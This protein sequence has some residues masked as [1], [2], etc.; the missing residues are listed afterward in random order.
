MVRKVLLWSVAALALLLVAVVLI[1]RYEPPLDPQARAVLE[2]AHEALPPEQNLLYALLGFDLKAEDFARAGQQRAQDLRALAARGLSDEEFSQQSELPPRDQIVIADRDRLGAD[3]DRLHLFQEAMAGVTNPAE[4]LA[5]NAIHL[6]RYEA[7]RH[8]P[9]FVDLPA[10]WQA[11]FVIRWSPMVQAGQLW[12]IWLADEI[13]KGRTDAALADLRDDADFWRRLMREKESSL[14]AQLI[15]SANLARDLRMASIIASTQRL[16]DAQLA[17]LTEIARPL[18]AQ[19]TGLRSTLE[20]EYRFMTI[21]IDRL[22]ANAS[23]GK[24]APPDI[25]ERI[26]YGFIR[27]F[28]VPN[29]ARNE[30]FT[31]I[32]RTIAQD[33]QGCMHFDRSLEALKASPRHYPW[34]SWPYNPVGKLVFSMGGEP[35]Y[36]RYTG[37]RCNV[38]SAQ[39]VLALQLLI[40]RQ[41]LT[42]AQI[43]A[44]IAKAGPDY[45]DPY[46]GAPLKWDA[47]KHTLDAGIRADSSSRMRLPWKI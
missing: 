26:G 38:V 3:D 20:Y 5:S 19:E 24:E 43:P 32:Q 29:T 22:L 23:H 10:D 8:Y 46:T 16:N 45:A 1:N 36:L 33:A 30:V 15:F 41:R 25:A 31:G 9:R 39:R 34:W 42:D 44:A 37:M 13:R 2:H 17:V 12:S 47:V 11:T 6:Q 21:A 40:H 7:L 35:D 28:F 4:L 18:T 14:I 27:T